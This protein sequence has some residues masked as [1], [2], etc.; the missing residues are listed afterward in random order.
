[1]KYNDYEMKDGILKECLN[2]HNELLVDGSTYCH[3]CGK[4]VKNLCMSEMDMG[5]PVQCEAA[6]LHPL[7]ANARYCP[8]CGNNTLFRY[9]DLLPDWESENNISSS[10][11]DFPF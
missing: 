3:I 4:P 6:T 5:Q 9:A 8:Y 2:C 1:M 7:P 11:E 10:T